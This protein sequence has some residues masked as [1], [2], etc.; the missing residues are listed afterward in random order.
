MDRKHNKINAYTAERGF[1]VKNHIKNA[2]RSRLTGKH[3][4]DLMRIRSNA[5]DDLNKCPANRYAK[6]FLDEN[7]FRTDD[8]KGKQLLDSDESNQV[9][10]HH[11]LKLRLSKPL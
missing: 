1:T 9:K 11:S 8:P 2:W 4:D 3:L 7:R 10:K 5:V 6:Q